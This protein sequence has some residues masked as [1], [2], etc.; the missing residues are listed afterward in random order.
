MWMLGTMRINCFI[1]I[2]SIRNCTAKSRR[3]KGRW[4]LQGCL[5][6]PLW[7][8]TTWRPWLNSRHIS[9]RDSSRLPSPIT[10]PSNL[11]YRTHFTKPSPPNTPT[12]S[13]APSTTNQELHSLA[14]SSTLARIASLKCS[15]VFWQARYRIWTRLTTTL[16]SLLGG[17]CSST[18]CF[19]INCRN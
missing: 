4:S 16:L 8:N 19:P 3:R 12:P 1:T 10:T 7:T 17:S 5:R 2:R 9:C 13:L 18:N 11:S 6:L 15:T 14:S